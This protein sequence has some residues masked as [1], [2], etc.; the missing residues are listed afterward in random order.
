MAQIPPY[1]KEGI[2]PS[3][4]EGLVY[5]GKVRDVYAIPDR[6]NWLLQIATNSVSIFD[7]VLGQQ[8][9]K[10]GESLTALTHFWFEKLCQDIPHHL[11]ASNSQPG[12]NAV[13]DIAK[14]YSGIPVER[15]LVVKKGKPCKFELIFRKHLGG[16]VY[17]EYQETRSVA[18]QE[19][20]P[21]LPQWAE[22]KEAI[23][24]PS[25]KAHKGHDINISAQ[26]FFAQTGEVGRR[27]VVLL[28]YLYEQ[29]Y[30]Y[31]R[32]KGILLLDTKFEVSFENGVIT[33]IDEILTPDSSRYMLLTAWLQMMAEGTAAVFHD[34]Q[35][36]RVWGLETKTPW[37]DNIKGLEPENDVHVQHVQGHIVVPADILQ[38]AQDRYL[39]IFQMLTG[40]DLA[41]YQR[42]QMG[43]AV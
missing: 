6:P 41:T 29:A 40:M 22:L 28:K 14:L 19:L 7:I 24:T 12:L 16:S 8:I 30:E 27:A 34:K 43:I 18:G 11:V 20:P 32:A 23:F 37:S 17:T 38:T 10:K 13:H 2:I 26:S 36:V 25:T 39:E 9:G 5:Q 42:D 33:I 21:G 15:A 35:V 4:A 1:R 3:L 31:A